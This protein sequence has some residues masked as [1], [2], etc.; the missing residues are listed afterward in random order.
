VQG[1][2]VFEPEIERVP[3]RLDADPIASPH[4]DVVEP[5]AVPAAK[6]GQSVRRRDSPAV[7]LHTL[8]RLVM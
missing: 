3:I 4:Q 1:L 2:G 7:T 5:H 6:S 8:M